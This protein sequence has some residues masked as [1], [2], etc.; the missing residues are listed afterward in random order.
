M[1]S[2]KDVIGRLWDN[3]MYNYP[4]V[5]PLE[6]IKLMEAGIISREEVRGLMWDKDDLTEAA[7]LGK[8]ENK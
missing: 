8:K 1:T 2:I 7:E 4:K 5:K 3:N 6:Y